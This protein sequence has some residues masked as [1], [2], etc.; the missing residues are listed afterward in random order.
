MT[1]AAKFFFVTVLAYS[2]GA[3]AAEAQ[4]CDG[5]P[6]DAVLT[7]PDPVSE[8][9]KISC[10]ESG[11]IVT[12]T[13]GYGWF[14]HKSKKLISFSAQPESSNEKS[15][16][17]SFY[18]TKITVEKLSEA[19]G[20][21]LADAYMPEVYF[22]ITGYDVPSEVPIT[23]DVTLVNN[24]GQRLGLNIFVYRDLTF[25]NACWELCAPIDGF[26]IA[27]RPDNLMG[28]DLL[29]NTSLE[30]TRAK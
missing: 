24:V 11:H 13:S 29:P 20:E 28:R 15:G 14:S 9:A 2:G 19:V 22:A 7:I 23:Y 1:Q 10:T 16:K 6:R 3:I 21:V 12:Y 30:R 26:G 27:K 25:A 5:A 8:W 17:H 4:N 18:F